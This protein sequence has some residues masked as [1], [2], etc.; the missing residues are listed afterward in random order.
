MALAEPR[1]ARLPRELAAPAGWVGLVLVVAAA[2]RFGPATAFP[3]S[4]V[5]APVLG[6]AAVLAAGCAAPAAG[7]GLLL[8]RRPLQWLGGVS[9]SLYLWHYPVLVLAP[10][11]I[12]RALDPLASCVAV[13]FALSL[14]VLTTILVERPVRFSPWLAARRD[15][16]ALTGGALSCAAAAIAVLVATSAP[17]LAGASPARLAS[18]TSPAPLGAEAPSGPSA[19]TGSTGWTG[20]GAS[21]SGAGGSGGPRLRRIEAVRRAQRRRAADATAG[22]EAMV[23]ASAGAR[24]VPADVQPPLAEASADE[25]APFYDGCFDSFTDTEVHACDYGDT[26]SARSVVLFGDSHALMWFPAVDAIAEERHVHLVALA[27]A[28]CPPLALEV[29]SPDLDEWYSQCDD[30]RAAAIE[31]IEELR[32]GVV[33]LGFSREYGVGNDHVSVYGAAWMH[34]LAEMIATLRATGRAVVVIG[35][36]PYPPFVVPDCLAQY[37]D[38]PTQCSMPDRAPWYDAAGVAAEEAVVRRAG[39]TYVDTQ[40]WFCTASRCLT[41]I[42][43]M[44]AYRDDNH[45]SATYASYLTPALGAQLALDTHGSF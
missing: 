35:P 37:L 41:M 27:K 42:G 7:A 8:D 14:A 28:T 13:G 22:V 38:D 12:H 19:G 32:P 16:S 31:R 26:S 44:V 39:G 9:Y 15:L 45:I 6:A 30:W 36:V 2:L 25:P 17:S 18:L 23:A 29:F 3:G 20:S 21:G 11:V 33:I 4:A 43:G 10:D 1:L 34:G 5:L 24:A 40:R